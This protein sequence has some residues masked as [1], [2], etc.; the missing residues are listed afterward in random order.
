MAAYDELLQLGFRSVPG[1]VIGDQQIRGFDEKLLK[2][3]LDNI[4]RPDS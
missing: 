2:Q 3:A 1:T 4:T